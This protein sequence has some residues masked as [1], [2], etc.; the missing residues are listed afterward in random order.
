MTAGKLVD[1]Q[2]DIELSVAVFRRIIADRLLHRAALDGE[3]EGPLGHIGQTRYA[4]PA[5]TVRADFEICLSFAEEPVLNKDVNFGVIDGLVGVV[6]YREIRAAGTESTIH[7]RD[8]F[9]LGG[10]QA[11]AQ[12]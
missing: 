5:V 9:R 10:Q 1:G 11:T 7:N 4:G 2:R 12:E 6:F 3:L 8:L